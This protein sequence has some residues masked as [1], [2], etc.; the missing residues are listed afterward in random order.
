MISHQKNDDDVMF[1]MTPSHG[2]HRCP[3]NSHWLVDFARGVLKKPLT[4]G[5]FDDRWD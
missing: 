5:L 4:T 3:L 2:H 1:T